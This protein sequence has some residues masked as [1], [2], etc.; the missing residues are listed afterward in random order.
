MFQ[1][2]PQEYIASVKIRDAAQ[3]I[4]HSLKKHFLLGHEERTNFA[5]T[6]YLQRK[7][8]MENETQNAKGILMGRKEVR[9]GDDY[10]KTLLKLQMLTNLAQAAAE[11][12]NSAAR[13]ATK[14]EPVTTESYSP[15]S[16]HQED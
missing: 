6:D 4:G 2:H 14:Q 3:N 15:E 5:V 7:I 10:S 12:K 11:G 13:N 16:N 9:I 1:N 8:L